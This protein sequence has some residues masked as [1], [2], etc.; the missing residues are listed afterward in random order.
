[1]NFKQKLEEAYNEWE[2]RIEKFK[3]DI[4]SSDKNKTVYKNVKEL[5]NDLGKS[6]AVFDNYNTTLLKNYDNESLSKK[7]SMIYTKT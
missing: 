1:M 3:K 4:D 5:K 7:Q 2:K 6:A